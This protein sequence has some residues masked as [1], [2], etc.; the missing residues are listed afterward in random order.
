MSEIQ[1]CI[2]EDSTSPPRSDEKKVIGVRATVKRVNSRG[3][4]VAEISRDATSSD[5]TTA[6]LRETIAIQPKYGV[7][8]G[9][10]LYC[11]V[12]PSRTGSNDEWFAI[13]C[14]ADRPRVSKVKWATWQDGSRCLS[15]D[16]L[17]TVPGSNHDGID[18]SCWKCGL[19]LIG[20][21]QVHRIK[22][23]TVWT[24]TDKVVGDLIVDAESGYNK[25]KRTEFHKVFCGGCKASVATLYKRP[26]WDKGLNAMT[27]ERTQPTPCLKVV[28]VEM[29]EGDEKPI[30]RTVL[31][32]DD[33]DTVRDA[34]ES[35]TTTENARLKRDYLK[36]NGRVDRLNYI[37][38]K[39]QLETLGEVAFREDVKM[40]C[41]ICMEDKAPVEGITCESKHFTCADCF[42]PYV[43]MKLDDEGL[44]QLDEFEV[45]CCE[46]NCECKF[47]PQVVDQHVTR[48]VHDMIVEARK[49]L[50]EKKV[51]PE[52]EKTLRLQLEAEALKTAEQRMIDEASRKITEDILNKKCPRCGQVFDDFDGCFALRCNNCP[53]AFCAC[54][55]KDCGNDAHRHVARECEIA[56]DVGL[57]D[58]Y[59]KQAQFEECMK[60]IRTKRIK[61]M[62][63]SEEYRSVAKR[64][65]EK[66][67]RELGD[68]G[69]DAIVVQFTPE[70][71]ARQE[72]EARERQEREN[73]ELAARLD[74]ERQRHVFE[75]YARHRARTEELKQR[76]EQRAEQTRRQRLENE[77]IQ[78]DTHAKLRRDLEARIARETR[79]RETRENQVEHRERERHERE[80]REEREYHARRLREAEQRPEEALVRRFRNMNQNNPEARDIR[81]FLEERGIN[82]GRGVGDAYDFRAMYQRLQRVDNFRGNG[83]HWVGAIGGDWD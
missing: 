69:L 41:L 81:A 24:S 64:I 13:R 50:H 39:S 8:P 7:K 45:K 44:M 57:R 72:R 35:L 68:V 32:G 25:F 40:R 52:I 78:N 43:K 5:G 19:F 47:D 36:K 79:D 75:E 12:V 9:D 48:D 55:L 49:K 20:G 16:L 58:L 30:V 4:A 23:T 53:C 54:C 71:A 27:D 22:D 80:M 11:N 82:A 66:L 17:D 2:P 77:R 62:L 10:K 14:E 37:K 6:R 67:R 31:E 29:R 3:W 76:E 73:E 28:T 34:I 74:E 42:S 65:V 61:E 70:L 26:F 15:F 60:R 18:L 56:R 63:E 46:L 83:R 59:G 33:E 51:T 38:R 21:D 1:P